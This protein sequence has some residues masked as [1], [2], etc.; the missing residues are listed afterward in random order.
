MDCNPYVKY[1]VKKAFPPITQ[2]EVIYVPKLL[3]PLTI[4]DL[5]QKVVKAQD[6][7]A[8]YFLTRQKDYDPTYG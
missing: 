4:S 3:Q 7:V 5:A 6:D 8:P 2:K 1:F